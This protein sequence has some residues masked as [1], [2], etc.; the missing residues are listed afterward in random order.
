MNHIVRKD[1]HLKRYKMVRLAVFALMDMNQWREPYCQISIVLI[2]MNAWV[3]KILVHQ[4][5]GV[6][7]WKVISNVSKKVRKMRNSALKIII[8]Q[9]RVTIFPC[10]RTVGHRINSSRYSEWRHKGIHSIL[11]LIDLFPILIRHS[12][13]T[14]VRNLWQCKYSLKAKDYW[15]TRYFHR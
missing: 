9:V 1:E 11:I 3:L 2:L 8:L 4:I 10:S 15:W 13:Y 12:M 14:R 5:I 6:K 7:M